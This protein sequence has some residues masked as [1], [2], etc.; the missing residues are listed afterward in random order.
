MLDGVQYVQHAHEAR[1]DLDQAAGQYGRGSCA[2]RMTTT[3]TV[4]A[5]SARRRSARMVVSTRRPSLN[6]SKLLTPWILGC[7]KLG[8]SATPSPSFRYPH[9]DQRLDLEA[10]A[11]QPPVSPG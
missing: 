1:L 3:G 8:T 5:A 2:R 6:A 11:P 9:M 4:T 7:S 10:V